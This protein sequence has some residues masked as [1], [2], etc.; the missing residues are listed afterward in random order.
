ME[1]LEEVELCFPHINT[2]C[3]RTTLPHSELIYSG[4]SCVTL[5]TV[6]LNLLVI[7][8]ISHFRQLHTTT[9]LLLLSLAVA[10]FCVGVLQMPVLLLHNQGCWY[11]GDRMCGVHYFLGFL[12]I[13]VSVGSMVLI[14]VDRYIAICDPMFY[15]TRVTL[16]R[17]KLSV[18]LCWIFSTIHS[19]WILRDFLKEPNRFNSCYGNCVVVVSFAEGLVDLVVTLLGPILVIAVLYLRVFV[20]VV[21]QA[22]AMRGH[23]VERS[24]S[25]KATKSELKAARTLG[26]VIVVFLLCSCPYYC[27]AVAAESNLVGASY[28]ALQIWLLYFNSCL[29]PVIYV[30]FYPWFRKA[31][32][33]IVTLKILQT[34][35]REGKVL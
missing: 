8:S 26:I 11:L 27:F 31:I 2:S 34:G 13:S 25:V 6:V 29:N 15:T 30:F 16:K 35:S 17:V 3:R 28:A 5:L 18:C 7:I 12:V 4:L 24:E 21:S 9:N 14:S 22:R 10:D 32:K 33:H 23:A 19:S 20:V 1:A